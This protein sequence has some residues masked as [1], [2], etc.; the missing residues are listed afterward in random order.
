MDGS[1]MEVIYCL[2]VPDKWTF[3]FWRTVGPA[4]K[5]GDMLGEA[6]YLNI[7]IHPILHLPVTSQSHIT[8]QGC[9]V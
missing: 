7:A 2:F 3:P 8:P 6:C 5:L 1:N 9:L 4:F